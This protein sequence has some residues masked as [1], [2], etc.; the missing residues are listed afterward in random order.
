MTLLAL[1]RA[2]PRAVS[3]AAAHPT[4][5]IAHRTP[6][7]LHPTPYT[8]HSTP[9]TPYTLHLTPHTL[10]PT[11]YR[12]LVHL[13]I[14]LLRVDGG[15][16]FLITR[17]CAPPRYKKTLRVPRS[18]DNAYP[19]DLTIYTAAQGGAAAPACDL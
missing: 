6:Y 10:H 3:S 15:K 13:G 16:R 5:Y 9:Y 8:L 17:E 7:T 1:R 12:A 2:R 11:P 14:G 18:W 4:P 19:Y